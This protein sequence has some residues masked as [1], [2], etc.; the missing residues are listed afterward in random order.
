MESYLAP[1]ELILSLFLQFLFS[2]TH[3]NFNNMG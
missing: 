3:A 1:E 2:I